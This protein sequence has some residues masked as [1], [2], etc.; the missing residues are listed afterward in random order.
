M[1]DNIKQI[2]DE[3]GLTNVQLFERMQRLGYNGAKSTFLGYLSKQRGLPLELISLIA[4]ALNVPEQYLFDRRMETLKRIITDFKKQNT[5]EFTA[6]LPAT[7]EALNNEAY[8]KVLKYEIYAGGGQVGIW[9]DALLADSDNFYVIDKR[10]L[11]V[12]IRSSHLIMMQI[13][14]DSMEP[15][16]MEGDWVL[17]EHRNGKPVKYVNGV[18]IVK[19]GD[20]VQIKNI[21]FLPDGDIRCSSYN[22]A[23]APFQPMKDFGVGWD[24]LG[25]VCGKLTIGTGFVWE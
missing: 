8:A 1:I 13:V 23:Y 4:E 2:L 11:P 22:P 14:G 17:I 6:M 12:S 20:T 10:L 25:K 19:Y 5:A 21:E 16:Y 3:Q 7:A 18:H 9:D 24:I 15:K